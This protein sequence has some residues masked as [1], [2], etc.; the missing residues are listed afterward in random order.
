[1]ETKPALRI[2]KIGGAIVNDKAQLALFYKT[3]QQLSGATIIVHGG[4]NKASQIQEALGHQAQL[5]DGR[6][7][8]DAA[9][10]EVVTMVYAG[11]LNKTIVAG[12]QAVGI[13]AMGLSGVDGNVVTAHKRPVRPI[14][15]GFVGDIHTI[16]VLRL[17]DFIRDGY[18][19]VLCAI[20]H[21]GQGQL[22]N[23]NADTLAAAIATAMSTLYH[24]QLY[25]CFDERG[26]LKEVDNPDTV[27]P[28]INRNGYSDLKENDQIANGMLPKLHTAFDALNKG[29]LHVHI[30]NLDMLS[31]TTQN[32]TILCL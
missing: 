12:L 16:N 27:I 7:I 14:D 6:R 29:V 8:T 13:N 1:M 28:L 10:L 9:T 21:D 19:P 3:I 5:I 32:H 18:T 17:Q 4:G 15:Y 11:L 30:G 22:L 2:I 25:Y 24:T 26:V 20:T 31:N 23:T